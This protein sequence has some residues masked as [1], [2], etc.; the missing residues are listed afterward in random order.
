MGTN[1]TSQMTDLTCS[2]STP[3]EELTYFLLERN[4][5][6]VQLDRFFKQ[7]LQLNQVSIFN[8]GVV[9][10]NN[11]ALRNVISSS[12]QPIHFDLSSADFDPEG[13]IQPNDVPVD[14]KQSEPESKEP[15]APEQPVCLIDSPKPQIEHH[16]PVHP[17]TCDKCQTR[18][19]GIRYKCLQCPD[20]DLCEECEEIQ[21]SENFHDPTH[22]FAKL[23]RPRQQPL[24]TGGSVHPARLRPK[25]SKCILRTPKTRIDTLESKL[26][27][28]EK[29]INLLSI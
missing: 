26:A 19:K 12:E 28:L 17:A 3:N 4:V 13:E 11:G 2:Y 20:Y 14:L 22:T 15:L 25:V 29:Q 8:Q 23:R 27:Q 5:S 16:L 9:I 1:K 21:A 10:G 24:F 7:T 18:I 6:F